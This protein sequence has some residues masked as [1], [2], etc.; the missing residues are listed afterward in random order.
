M[1]AL[2]E[3]LD[4][5]EGLKRRSVRNWNASVLSFCLLLVMQI[6]ERRRTNKHMTFA[7]SVAACEPLWLLLPAM[8]FDSAFPLCWQMMANL[9]TEGMARLISLSKSADCPR[10]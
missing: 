6:E 5:E 3:V 7:L 1:L 8:P 4:V 10:M 2:D 9:L